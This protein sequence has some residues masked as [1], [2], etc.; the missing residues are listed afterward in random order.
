M[1]R[2]IFIASIC[3]IGCKQAI[4]QSYATDIPY[5][6]TTQPGMAIRLAYP[7]RSVEDALKKYSSVREIKNG[8]SS[9]FTVFR[10]IML[11]DDRTG[12]DLYFKT[13]Q[14]DKKQKD[15][16]ILYLFP[17]KESQ[18]MNQRTLSDSSALNQAGLYLDSLA[19]FIAAFDRQ[20]RLDDQQ[21]VLAKAQRTML[22]LQSDQ[23]SLEKKLKGLQSDLEDNK[24][25]QVKVA[26]DLQESVKSDSDSKN[27]L[28]KRLNRLLDEENSLQKKIRRTQDDLTANRTRQEKQQGVLDR[29]Q[30]GLEVLKGNG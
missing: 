24:K 7:E 29:E 12:H 1:Y 23:G 14:A 17:V 30:Q 18:D 22:D 13:G 15:N 6:K 5:K 16:T 3:W 26:S 19:P 21:Q 10:S 4:G 28:H 11:P 2:Q 27:K 8:S 9:G 20:T 25:E